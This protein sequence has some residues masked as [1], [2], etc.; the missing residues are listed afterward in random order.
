MLK[1][2]GSG[3]GVGKLT[4][5]EKESDEIRVRGMSVGGGMAPERWPMRL[6][7]TPFEVGAIF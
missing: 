4:F 1:I 7:E 6:D 5:I 3:V 2:R